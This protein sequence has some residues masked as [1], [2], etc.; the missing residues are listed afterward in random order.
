MKREGKYSWKVPNNIERTI[1]TNNRNKQ[2][3]WENQTIIGQKVM[4]NEAKNGNKQITYQ[5]QSSKRQKM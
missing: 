3:A 5:K 1:G 4:D 2:S